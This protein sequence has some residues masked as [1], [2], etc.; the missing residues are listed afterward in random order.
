VLDTAHTYVDSTTSLAT[1]LAGIDA[2][3]ATNAAAVVT[4]T[5]ARVSGDSANASSITTLTSTVA[6]HTASIA[7]NATTV[8]GLSAQYTVKVDVNGRVSGYGLASTATTSGALSEFVVIANKFS[9]VDPGATGSAPIV[10]FIVTGGVVYMQNVVIQS[11]VIQNLAVT[12]AKIDNLAVG[13][14]QIASNAASQMISNYAA[15]AITTTLNI[16][17]HPVNTTL[18]SAGIVTTGGAVAVDV[19]TSI[20]FSGNPTVNNSLTSAVLEVFMDGASIGSASWDGALYGDVAGPTPALPVMLSVVNAPSAGAHNY[21]LH[22]HLDG[23][24][25]ALSMTTTCTNNFIKI[26]EIKK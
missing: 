7:T 23:S 3:N 17:S 6:G 10:P 18:V 11:A 20:V 4:E 22:L 14:G 2:F 9:I 8:S 19:G 13:S 25:I 5:T 21:S 16:L 12:T 15:G 24:G 1:R 26:R